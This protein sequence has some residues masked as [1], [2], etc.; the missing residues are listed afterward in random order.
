MEKYSQTQLVVF[1][2]LGVVYIACLNN[3]FWP[4]CSP[5]SGCILSYNKGNY[6]IYSYSV[7]DFVNEISWGTSIKFP[8]KMITAVGN[9]KIIIV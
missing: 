1:V 7:F 5:L 9:L 6:K 8:F 2:F 4:L 3:M